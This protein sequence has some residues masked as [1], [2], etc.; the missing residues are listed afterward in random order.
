MKNGVSWLDVRLGV[1]MLAKY[2]GLTIVG[3]LGMAVAIAIGAGFFAFLHSHLYPKLPLP[4]GDRIIALENWNVEVNNEERQAVHDLVAW[5]QEMK[6]VVDI[7]AFRNVD[8]NLIAGEGPPELVPVAEMTASAFRVARV[9]PVLGR[10][11][12]EDDEREGA[13]PV[14]VIGYDVWQKRFAGDSKI[15]GREIR[16]GTT[17]ETIVGVMPRGFAFPMSHRLGTALRVNASKYERGEGHEIF[18]LARL[19]PGRPLEDAQAELSA[20]GRRSTAEFPKT[21]AVLRPQAMPYTCPLIDI[22]DP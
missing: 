11:L 20:I 7:A 12:V 6:S 13:A 1:R 10:Y 8:Q 21:H 15:V 18:I 19:A 22:Q 4:E 5:R 2:P 17:R 14:V 3:G 9:A 16:F